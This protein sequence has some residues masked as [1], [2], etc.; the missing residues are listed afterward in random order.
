[1]KEREMIVYMNYVVC[2]IGPKSTALVRTAHNLATRLGIHLPALS[3]DSTIPTPADE[4][5]TSEHDS[6]I[7]AVKQAQTEPQRK[8][9]D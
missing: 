1:M 6:N 5:D 7:D 2:I 4:T 8:K 9:N 3:V